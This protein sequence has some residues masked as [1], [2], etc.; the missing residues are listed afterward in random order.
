MHYRSTYT[1]PD[2]RGVIR[3]LDFLRREREEECR[4]AHQNP[5]IEMTSLVN[6]RFSIHTIPLGTFLTSILG[7]LRCP[8]WKAM[9]GRAWGCFEEVGRFMQELLECKEIV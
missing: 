1:F 9:S 3:A 2:G 4:N 5:Y 8:R 6:L 7:P